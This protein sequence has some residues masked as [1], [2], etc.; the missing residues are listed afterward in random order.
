MCSGELLPS[1]PEVQ[2]KLVDSEDAT[3]QAEAA[4][5]P[6]VWAANKVYIVNVIVF[7]AKYDP[8]KKL[9][10]ARARLYIILR[11]RIPPRSAE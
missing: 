2:Q 11:D 7:L 4:H 6:G 3:V 8:C 9:W 10:R 1:P 5:V